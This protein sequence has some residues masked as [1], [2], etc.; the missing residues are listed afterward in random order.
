MK[1][2]K[3]ITIAVICVVFASALFA[4][5]AEVISVK[6]KVEVNRNNEWIALNVGDKVSET[7]MVSTGFQSEAKIK[8]KD[9][10]M[11]LGALSR[12]TLSKMASTETKDVVN[13]YLNTGAVRSKVNHSADKKVSYT[14]RN[15][16]AVASVRGTDF[17]T[18]DD[19]T[20]ICYSGAVVL[21]PA[22]LYDYKPVSSSD[23][24]ET[25]ETEFADPADGESNAGTDKN[26]IDPAAPDGGVVV[27]GGQAS[28][29]TSTGKAAST[30]EVAVKQ[31]TAAA[32]SV[33][34]AASSE[35]VS[36]A[37]S[38]A[39]VSLPQNKAPAKGEVILV[40]EFPAGG[41]GVDIEWENKD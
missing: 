21:T 24:E 41:I 19:G 8:Y 12:V 27:L 34:T 9:S 5:S 1:A 17:L 26:D 3:L 29:I 31:A 37:P 10:V 6:G 28:E 35:A 39:N 4:D 40:P 11:Q 2:K 36:S 23:A 30:F 14:V 16:V 32:S 13:V 38:S 33:T 7:E 25:E 20:V 22:A 18:C 15:Q